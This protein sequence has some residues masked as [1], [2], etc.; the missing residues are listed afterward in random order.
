M[1]WLAVKGVP[2]A[3]V[4]PG[5]S[6]SAAHAAHLSDEAVLNLDGVPMEGSANAQVVMVE[7]GDFECEYCAQFALKT[8]P[9][10]VERYVKP[11]RLRIAFENFPLKEHVNA[12]PA[13]Q[14]GACA[15]AERQFWPMYDLLFRDPHHLD[16][17][18]LIDRAKQ[19]KLD[20][21]RFTACLMGPQK[22]RL[23]MDNMDARRLHLSGVP[24]FAIGR[25][26]A[27]TFIKPTVRL[28]GAQDVGKFTSALDSVL[29]PAPARST[30]LPRQQPGSAR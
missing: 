11:G 20:L 2:V 12:V 30:D 3:K 14:A 25:M 28:A 1:I 21:P 29:G 6:S 23:Q 10:L 7:F 26:F 13:A 17:A 19:V 24:A 16:Q 22:P 15:T 27:G 18:S 8:L 9:V 4:M 5:A